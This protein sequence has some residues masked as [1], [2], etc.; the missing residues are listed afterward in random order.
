MF[1]VSREP[2]LTRAFDP[3]DR[4]EVSSVYGRWLVEGDLNQQLAIEN[5]HLQIY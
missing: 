2:L 3:I 1:G 4:F 5:Q